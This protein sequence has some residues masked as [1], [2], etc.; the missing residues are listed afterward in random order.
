MSG[1]SRPEQCRRHTTE[2]R[3][4]TDRICLPAPRSFTASA[5]DASLFAALAKEPDA[6][7][8]PNVARFYRH[9][10]ALSADARKK[11]PSAIGGVSTG[12][13]APAKAAPAK[14]AAD[15]ED[16]DLFGDDGDAAAASVQ[17][18][19]VREGRGGEWV[20]AAGLHCAAAF[21][22]GRLLTHAPS[23]ALQP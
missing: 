22:A 19:K 17:A 11:L 3:D 15:D 14:K 8:F 16:A 4:A 5:A 7:K 20:G 2:G 9:I 1:A 23:P 12:G 10:A 6:A 18:A 13:A 21:A